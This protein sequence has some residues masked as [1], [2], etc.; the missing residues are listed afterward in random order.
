MSKV[1]IAFVG[2]GFVA[3]F[4]RHCLANHADHF[5]LKGV[6]D[7]DRERLYA[8][9][10]TW[11]DVAYASLEAVLADPNVHILVNLTDPH[12]HFDVSNAALRAGKHV[13]TEKPLGMTVSEAITLRQIARD[14]GLRISGAP[15]NVLG[16]TA[17]TLWRAVRENRAG[18]IRLIYA[19]MDDGMVHRAP[20]RDWISKSG[21]PWPADGEFEV[22]CT[23]EHAGY[24]VT[25]LAAM[26]GPVQRVSSF[27]AVIYPDKQTDTPIHCAPDMSVGCLEFAN[28]VVARITNSVVAPYD[29]RLR[30]IGDEGILEVAEPWN[31]GSKVIL[32]PTVQTR[33]GRILERRLGYVRGTVLPHVRQVPFKMGRG[34]PTMDFMRGV[35]ELS[36]ALIAERKCR[37]DEDFAVHITEVTEMLQHP[38][39][40][41]MPANVQSTFAPIDPM[42]WG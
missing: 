9:T 34:A 6:Y 1:G 35:R 11:G 10:R 32:R 20:Y 3:D 2:C 27:S 19:E 5:E 25:I 41:T 39:R 33:L 24:T 28:G 18:R 12:N 16:E 26:F 14:L 15:C 21:R 13:Y 23:Y 37:L 8:F 38:D 17:Q 7:R 29:H 36:D 42:D 40:F 22:G 30:M 31:Y 4:Y